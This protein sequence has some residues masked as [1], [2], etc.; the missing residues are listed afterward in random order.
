MTYDKNHILF[1]STSY[2]EYDRRMQR[3]IQTLIH[4]GYKVSWI[5]RSKDFHVEIDQLNYIP[6][7]TRAKSG[8]MFYAQFNIKAQKLALQSDAGIISAVDL[9]TIM[10]GSWAL[11]E[12]RRLVFDSHEYFTEV[13]EL[14]GRN[15]VKNYWGRLGRKY[16]PRARKAY[17]VNHSLARILE[18]LYRRKFEVVRNVPFAE[19]KTKANS[20][21]AKKTISYVGVLNIGRGLHQILDAMVE[22]S[23]EYHLQLIGDGDITQHLKARVQEL[24]LEDR[25]HFLGYVAP[26]K[27]NALLAASWCGINLLDSTSLNY[28]YSLANKYFD[29]IHAGCPQICMSFPEYKFLNTQYETAVLVDNLEPQSIQRAIEKLGRTNTYKAIQEECEKAREEYTWEKEEEQLLS[30]YKQ[31]FS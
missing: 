26:E 8:F 31:V 25:V 11:R 3:I 14:K 5:A 30:I 10:A 21:S 18:Q 1:I 22:L 19:V 20:Y 24:K 4:A 6:I 15:L 17:T 7:S 13:P 16:I 29:Y 27:I 9:D 23:P 2:A 28:Y 12:G